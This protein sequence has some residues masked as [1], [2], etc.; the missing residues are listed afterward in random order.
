[1]VN[2]ADAMVANVTGALRSKGMWDSTLL[3]FS[4]DNGGPIYGNGSAGANNYPLKGGKMSKLSCGSRQAQFSLRA[5]APGHSCVERVQPSAPCVDSRATD[6]VESRRQLGR[7]H[8]LRNLNI[9]FH[10]HTATPS[11]GLRPH[12]ARAA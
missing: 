8:P 1:M 6:G 12:L 10:T 2:Y 3:I 5:R 4:T 9:I 7:W 11:G